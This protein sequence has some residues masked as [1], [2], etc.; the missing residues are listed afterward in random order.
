MF[1][2]DGTLVD[3]LKDWERLKESLM[4]LLGSSG[5]L[6][7]LFPSIEKMTK[8]NL[9]LRKRAWRLIEKYELNAVKDIKTDLE[10]VELFK[11]LKAKGYHIA[12]L[13][14]QGRHP[15]KEALK[16]L[17]LHEAFDHVITREET[18]S[19]ERQI[20]K[21]LKLF[22]VKP[23]QAMLIADRLH[24]IQTASKLGCMTVAIT[25]KGYVKADYKFANVKQIAKIFNL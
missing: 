25:R 11:K 10:L 19:R 23:N 8:N 1:D 16:K 15:L 12:L 14:L 3:L 9:E 21:L 24:D 17:G 2:F 18:T 5:P 7:P 20:K 22:N 6:T 4:K 13:T